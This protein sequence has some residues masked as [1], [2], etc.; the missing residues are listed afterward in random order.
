MLKADRV[1]VVLHWISR[2]LVVRRPVCEHVRLDMGDNHTPALQGAASLGPCQRVG[3]SKG[4]IG[5]SAQVK[6]GIEL[7]RR[8]RV[9]GIGL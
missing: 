5:L 7:I 2:D 1:D 9:S 6:A 4:S 8:N 3:L